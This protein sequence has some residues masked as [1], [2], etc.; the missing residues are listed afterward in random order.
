VAGQ[1][2]NTMGAAFMN[3]HRSFTDIQQGAWINAW[4]PV[5]FRPYARLMRLDRGIGT[6]L[7][8]IPCWWGLALGEPQ[9]GF[10]NTLYMILFAIGAVVMRGAGCVIN[11]LYDRELDAK[12]E[13]TRTRPLVTG[14]ISVKQAVIFLKI[15]LLIGLGVLLM[16]NRLTII[17]ALFSMVLVVTYPLMKRITWWPQLFLGLT[18]NWGALLGWTA[19]RD[20]IGLPAIALYCAGVCW[21][22]AYDTIYAHQDKRDDAIAG[23]KSTALLFGDQSRGWV[24]AFYA[25]TVFLLGLS[26]YSLHLGYAFYV[27][28]FVASV[29]EMIDLMRWRMNDPE[30]CLKRFR[31]NRDFGLLIFVGFALGQIV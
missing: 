21:T 29:M 17:L 31:H 20:N 4:L 27:F 1:P 2:S 25:L 19:V 30:S 3:L 23:I 9:A 11:D 16:F 6:W 24:A 28:L 10:P 8:L 15:L 7:L 26:G 12:V 18:F 5:W 14:E 13:R 22:L